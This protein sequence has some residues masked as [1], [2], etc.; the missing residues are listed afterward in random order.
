MLLLGPY[1]SH[2]AADVYERLK[3]DL[4]TRTTP[5]PDNA[6]AVEWERG[7]QLLDD[8]V[9]QMFK[10]L[11]EQFPVNTNLYNQELLRF[12]RLPNEST[13]LCYFRFVKLIKQSETPISEQELASQFLSVISGKDLKQI[14]TLLLVRPLPTATTKPN[15]PLT[16]V[17][18][19]DNTSAIV[20]VTTDSATAKP[21]LVVL[22]TGAQ[23]ILL[24]RQF[25]RSLNVKKDILRTNVKV[26]TAT[27]GTDS[28]VG[29]TKK[30]IQIILN[31]ENP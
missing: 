8:P 1:F 5:V 30:P 27:G 24:G 21:T 13:T 9:K 11:E 14:Q 17:A 29:I 3:D 12:S 7:P 18:M 25:A 20:Q 19:V 6:S 22:D 4:L 31:S 23:P 28:I 16:S 10:A 2:E 15:K 26:K